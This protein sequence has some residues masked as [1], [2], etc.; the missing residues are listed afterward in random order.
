MERSGYGKHKRHGKGTYLTLFTT[1][2][3]G[4]VHCLTELFLVSS[5]EH[6]VIIQSFLPDFHQTGITFHQF[7]EIIKTY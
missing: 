2:I 1:I 3:L 7:S 6:L 5:S 4:N